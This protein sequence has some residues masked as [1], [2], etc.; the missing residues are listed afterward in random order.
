MTIVYIEGAFPLIAFARPDPV[1]DMVIFEKEK[2]ETELM[3]LE[4]EWN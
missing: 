2:H 3:W 4:I 1:L